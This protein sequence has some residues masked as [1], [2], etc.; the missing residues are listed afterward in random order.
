MI[1]TI[2]DS[3]MVSS[4]RRS[5]FADGGHEAVQ[6]AQCV[7]EYNSH[8]GGVDLSDQLVTY[9][10]FVHRTVKWWRRVSFIL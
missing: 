9:Y 8:M 7:V 3:S 1:S 4:Q 2:H 10:N 6:K 5:R